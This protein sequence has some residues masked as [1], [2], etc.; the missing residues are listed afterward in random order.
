MPD[1]V[2]WKQV[3]SSNVARL[4]WRE[5]PPALLVEWVKGRVSEYD[6]V[7]EKLFEELT[8]A[9]SVGSALNERVKGKFNHFYVG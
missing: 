7:S 6:G 3:F 5:N 1:E 8:K 4:G 9:P 2:R